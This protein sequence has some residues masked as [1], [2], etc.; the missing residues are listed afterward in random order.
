MPTARR[1]TAWMVRVPVLA[2]TVLAL[3]VTGLASTVPGA[4]ASSP[5]AE[6][7]IGASLVSVSCQGP[8]WCMAVGTY[9]N[10][11]RKR[12][13]LAQTWDGKTWRVLKNVPG[14]SFSNVT[15]SSPWFCLTQGSTGIEVW[16][17]NAWRLTARPK[18]SISSITCGGVD[19]CAVLSN[20]SPGGV[21]EIWRG[22]TWRAYTA[23]TSLCAPGGPSG[24]CGWNAISCGNASNCMMVGTLTT[25]NAG[26][27][28]GS[29]INWNGKSWAGSGEMPWDGDPI[30]ANDV[31]CAGYF[32]MA[33]GGA[34][35]MDINGDIAGA[36]TSVHADDWTNASPNL[37]KICTSQGTCG[38]TSLISCGSAWNCMSFGLGGDLNWNGSTWTTRP[39]LPAGPHSRIGGLSCHRSWCIAVGYRSIDGVQQTLSEFFN[40]TA[41]AIQ[42][43][44][45]V[46]QT[47]RRWPENDSGPGDLPR[48]PGPLAA[49]RPVRRGGVP[50]KSRT[51]DCYDGTVPIAAHGRQ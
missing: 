22:R 50:R 16:Q 25:D 49:V 37:G 4:A 40:G 43:T 14:T 6:P 20:A 31:S 13:A 39:T 34:E 46:A 44:P 29:S 26:D 28:A 51:A 23:Q 42:P 33:V 3:A 8:D 1:R 11:T 9:V 36:A 19:L 47:P 7:A 21:A 48:S 41:W 2:L 45:K 32:C 5:S 18:H 17:H 10:S 12:H 35:Q 15:C 38:W 27:Q 30:A 24:P